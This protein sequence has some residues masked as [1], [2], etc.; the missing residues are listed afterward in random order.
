MSITAYRQSMKDTSAPR[1]LERRVFQQVTLQL[2]SA[3]RGEDRQA[4]IHAV[5]RNRMLWN[6]LVADLGE[7][8]NLLPVELRANLI[9]LG[10][11]VDRYSGQA[12]QSDRPLA[13]LVDVNRAIIQ[14][15]TD[16]R[17]D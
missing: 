16:R 12:L 13:P 17:P 14:G 15:L 4:R 5:S 2:E 6:T 8:G 3:G 9:S 11:W 7:E 10:L 1:E